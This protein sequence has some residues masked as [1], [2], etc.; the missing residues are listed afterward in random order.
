VCRGEFVMLGDLPPTIGRASYL[1]SHTKRRT[2]IT[3]PHPPMKPSG[4]RSRPRA[5][6]GKAEDLK[7]TDGRL[8]GSG[9][10]DS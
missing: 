1:P 10:A 7:K 6:A 3:Q 4:V 2:A 8:S 9:T 5:R